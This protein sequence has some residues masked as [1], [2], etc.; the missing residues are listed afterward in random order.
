MPSL[1]AGPP[2]V[3]GLKPDERVSVTLIYSEPAI[4]KYKYVFSG[5]E[6][7]ISENGKTLGKLAI[8]AEDAVH[9][10]QHLWAVERGKKAGRSVMGAPVYTIKHESSGKTIGTWTYRID[11]PKES[12]KP[13][14]SLGELRKRLP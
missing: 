8:T 11:E 2:K 14:L 5:S 3:E 12:R 6:V 10:D 7:T 13:V 1:L 9:I 4:T